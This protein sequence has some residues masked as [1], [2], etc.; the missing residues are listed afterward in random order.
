[1]DDPDFDEFYRGTW[2]RLTT[3]L[4]AL[5]GDLAEAQDLAQEAYAR[6]WQRWS[7]VSG[8]GDP[9]AWLRTVAYRLYVNRWRKLRNGVKAY[10]RHGVADAVAPPSENTV[11]LTNALRTLP[12]KQR[13]VIVL[14]HLF[15]LSVVEVAEQTGIPVNTVKTLL[16]RGRRTLA[17]KL[18]T[19]IKEGTRA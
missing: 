2:H 14:H 17:E 3:F 11:A 18:G 1:M 9:E 10:R 6:A 12:A 15:D 13:H 7:A 5:G 4:Y 19:E 8:Y 16:V